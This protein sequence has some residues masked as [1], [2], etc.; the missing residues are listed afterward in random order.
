VR[1]SLN[2]RRRFV[3]R[4]TPK[5]ASWLNAVEGFF[6]KLKKRR[7]KRRASRSLVDLQAPSIASLP[8][9]I[10]IPN[11]SSGPPI[12][13]HHRCCQTWVTNVRFQPLA[14][15]VLIKGART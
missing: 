14:R 6:A 13:T 15:H 10:T 7:L 3:F 8:R 11:P 5:S 4:Y 2:R 12:P 9:P 1:A